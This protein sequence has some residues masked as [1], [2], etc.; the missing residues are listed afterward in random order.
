MS[1]Q[2]QHLKLLK[3]GGHGHD[4][5]GVVATH[6]GELA[7]LCPSCPCPGVNLLDDWED[8]P[9]EFKYVAFFSLSLTTF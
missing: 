1:M 8:A 5:A 4:R 6:A 7:V 3:W 9:I 2:W